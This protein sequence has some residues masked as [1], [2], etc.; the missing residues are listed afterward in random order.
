MRARALPPRRAAV[1]AAWLL[2]LAI[3]V[4][5]C[6]GGAQD[7]GAGEQAAEERIF[8]AN[9]AQCHG[10]Q[11]G[12]TDQGPPLVHI[13]YEPGHHPDES[14]RRAVREGVAPHHWDFVPMPPQPRSPTTSSRRSS[15]TSATSSARRASS[16]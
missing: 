7:A 3:V 9:C 14:F 11:G 16:N 1:L 2:P 4:G 13:V 10:A 6:R 5:A 15:R 8:A 12:G